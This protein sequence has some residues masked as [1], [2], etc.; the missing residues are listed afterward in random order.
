M[1]LFLRVPPSASASATT[2]TTY[3]ALKLYP[4]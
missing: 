3:G 1:N 2:T 4:Y